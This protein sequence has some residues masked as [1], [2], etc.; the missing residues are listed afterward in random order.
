M[1]NRLVQKIKEA[2]KGKRK[3]FCAYLTLG[4]PKLSVTETL[5]PALEKAGADVIE[6]GFPFSDPLADGPTIQFA[7]AKAIEGGVKLKT[8]LNSSAVCAAKGSTSPFFFSLT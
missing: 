8:L 2:K 1:N 7:S 6:L 4:F 5:I 3:L